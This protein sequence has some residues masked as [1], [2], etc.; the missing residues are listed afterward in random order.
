[1]TLVTTNNGPSS[2]ASV[3]VRDTLPAGV[4][5]V[6]ATNGAVQS[7]GVV[8]SP[9]V[10][11]LAG[12][13]SLTYGE[14]VTA[15]APGTSL[16][17]ARAN[18]ATADPG[19]TDNKRAE[20][21]NR[22]AP[23]VTEQADLSVAKTGPAHVTALGSIPYTIVTGNAGPSAATSVVVRDLLPSGAAFVSA[24]NGGTES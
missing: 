19:G 4:T 10:A 24:D 13:G 7:G 5:F 3:V 8:T 6:S 14:T 1:Y 21:A 22:V 2:A 12:G 17:A 16:N 9:A 20:A 15:P 11:S 18:S 23:T